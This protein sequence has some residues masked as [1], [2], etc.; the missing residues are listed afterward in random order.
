[1][2]HVTLV[3][4]TIL[5]F[6]GI[7]EPPDRYDERE[8]RVWAIEHQRAEGYLAPRAAQLRAAGLDATIEIRLGQPA[9]MIVEAARQCHANFIAM[10]TH[11][12]SGLRRWALGSIADKV[13]QA[14]TTPVLVVRG[15]E[16][17]HPTPHTLKRIMVPLDG[18]SLA[19]QALPVA[20]DLAMHGLAEL[21]LLRVVA[22]IERHVGLRPHDRAIARPGDIAVGPY[23][24][25]AHDLVTCA[26]NLRREQI[27]AIPM[28]VTGQVAEVIVDEAVRR[29]VDIIVMATHGYSG[30]RRWALGSVADKVLHATTTPLVLVRTQ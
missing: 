1:M 23:E 17:A 30:L 24:Q 15:A 4:D 8:R 19:K 20:A 9:E 5:G 12:A 22:P 18:S 6:H 14:T 2:A 27:T 3:G 11:G 28:V 13:V 16:G 7:E 25:A 21:V 10:A 29:E 26:A